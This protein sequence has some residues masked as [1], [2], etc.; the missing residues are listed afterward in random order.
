MNVKIGLEIH[1]S[2]LTKTKLFCS[3]PA[4]EAIEPNSQT[5]PVC[6]GHPG[7]KPVVNKQAINF[8]IKLS[9]ALKCEISRELVFSRKS[10]FYPDLSKNYQITQYEIP[11]G[12]K[13]FIEVNEKNIEITRVHLEE[14]PGALVHLE[15][16][17]KS[18]F[19]L[20]DYNRSGLPLCE[21]VTEPTISSP[22]EARDFLKML[23][24]ILEYL[25]IFDSKKCELKADVNCSIEKSNYTRVEIKNITGFKEIEQALINELKRQQELI[26]SGGKIFQ[27]TRG[28]NAESQETFSLRKKET[29]DDYG[30][31]IDTDLVPYE[32]DNKII[33]KLQKEIPELPDERSKRYQ[34]RYKINK[35][36]ADVIIQDKNVADLFERVIKKIDPIIASQWF[37]HELLRLINITEKSINE[38]KIN[39]TYIIE[40]LRLIK[41]QKITNKIAKEILENVLIKNISPIEYVKKQGLEMKKDVNELVLLCK[42]AIKSSPDAVKDYLS[43]KEKS[44]N[45]IIGKVMNKTKGTAKPQ[46][47]KDII[48]KLLKEK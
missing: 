48:D 14:D 37:R 8:A 35:I 11:L 44:I 43:G 22:S 23:V 31:I 46:E 9:S 18:N 36:D 30:Y 28:W 6:L 16:I 32:L 24:S 3:C 25:E 38:L 1:A 42:E 20:V 34:K 33:K 29:E 40:L 27:E 10:Y 19:C 7:S 2:L 4:Y 17:S 13:G 21:I 39:E 26:K 45:F 15:G 47:L 12:K 5:C 41:D